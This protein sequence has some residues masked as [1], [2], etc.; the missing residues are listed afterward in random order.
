MGMDPMSMG[1]G[2]MAPPMMSPQPMRRDPLVDMAM[3]RD[4]MA[5]MPS[6]GPVYPRWLGEVKR[7][8]PAK[9]CEYARKRFDEY[10]RWRGAVRHD[11]KM[12]RM[13]ESGIFPDDAPDVQ[14]GIME[15]YETHGLVD[16]YNLAV[17]WLS[18]MQRRVV[19]HAQSDETKGDARKVKLACELLLA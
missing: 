15:A 17:S 9:M 16:E 12:V 11:L 7:P 5:N 14:S 6:L 10:A 18:G 8:D 19:K 4:S 13:S 1:M 3:L 2:G